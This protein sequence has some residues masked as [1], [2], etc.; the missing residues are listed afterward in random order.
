MKILAVMLVSLSVLMAESP[1][2]ARFQH[3]VDAAEHLHEL[4]GETSTVGVALLSLSEGS[5]VV[6][7]YHGKQGF[8]PASTTKVLT[9]ATALDF[10]G[11]DFVF[12]TVLEQAS[13]DV[14]IKGGGDPTLAE[15]GSDE[16]FATW[17]SA[18]KEAGV[19]AIKGRVIGDASIFEV[20]QRPGS[21]AWSDLGN[22]YA[23][24]ACGLNFYQNTYQAFFQPGAVGAKARFL[25]T[26]P[27]LPGVEFYNEMLTGSSESGDLGYVYAAAYGD[28]AFLRGSIPAG[29]AFSIKGALPDPALLCA[30]LFERYLK[31]QG[32]EVGNK[33]STIRK[34]RATGKLVA[35][36][37]HALHT[38]KSKPLREILIRMNHK[39]VNLLAESILKRVGGGSTEGG[40]NTV[41]AL[42][43]KHQISTIGFA[44]N[45]GSGLSRSN[46]VSPRQM[47]H[48]L[49]SADSGDHAEVFRRSLPVAGQS[50]TLK[51]VARGTAAAGRVRGKSG[52]IARV[53]CYVG[54]VD[55]RSGKKFAFAIMVN[56]YAGKYATVKPGIERVM[57]RMAE[58]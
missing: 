34:M 51:S 45:D 10:L 47:V 14:I 4:A 56:N 41:E 28:V 42:F 54:Y 33:A 2:P 57:A 25:R 31:K 49:K 8:I 52:T 24:G 38:H 1:P 20:Q 48:F 32:V 23:S 36:E 39:S 55:A 3:V 37:R 6:V 5:E 46:L 29:R 16:L 19:T 12:E 22:Y 40:V 13:D 50:G 9:A 21:W 26:E 27:I 30:Q 43:R 11:P 44:M 53:K 7:D 18:L 17:L 58:L 15:Y 35:S